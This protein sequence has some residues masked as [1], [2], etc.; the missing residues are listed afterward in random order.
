LHLPRGPLS[1]GGSP[2]THCPFAK[3]LAPRPRVRAGSD[4]LTG[5]RPRAVKRILRVRPDSEG[6]PL[7]ENAV[8]VSGAP[9]LANR[10]K[11]A[12]PQTV[13]RPDTGTLPDP[14]EWACPREPASAAHGIRL[15]PHEQA[16]ASRMSWLCAG[17]SA[18]KEGAATVARMNSGPAQRT[19]YTPN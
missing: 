14:L 15:T 2:G 13:G 3:E 17:D 11:C 1:S 7:L 19:T 16:L 12:R 9:S 4:R 8:R 5:A 18:A 6:T 10:S